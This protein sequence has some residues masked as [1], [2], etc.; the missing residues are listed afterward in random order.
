MEEMVAQ[1]KAILDSFV[2][3]I[4]EL[5]DT[6]TVTVNPDENARPY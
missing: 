6:I 5:L 1:L 2:N 3:W 4:K